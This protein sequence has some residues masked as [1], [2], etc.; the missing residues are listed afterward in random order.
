[1]E[2]SKGFHDRRCLSVVLLLKFWTFLLLHERH[3]WMVF[4]G[5]SWAMSDLCVIWLNKSILT[6]IYMCFVCVK[7]FILV[8]FLISNL[9]RTS[10][11]LPRSWHVI[12]FLEVSEHSNRGHYQPAKQ[13]I[14]LMEKILH[15]LGYINLVNNGITYQPQ[16]V[17]AGFLLS[18][19]WP[20]CF[21]GPTEA[22][23]I[24]ALPPSEREWYQWRGNDEGS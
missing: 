11:R 10:F 7:T 23:D 2:G 13:T 20:F 14:L 16:L 22:C 1:M 3:G 12:A 6:V 17:N 18:T 24:T 21:G 19:V 4:F 5:G 9:F 8:V 15:H